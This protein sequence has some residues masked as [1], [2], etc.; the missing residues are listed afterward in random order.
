MLIAALAILAGSDDESRTRAL[1]TGSDDHSGTSHTSR[2]STI[3]ALAI[4]VGSSHD[5]SG[6]S[7]TSSW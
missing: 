2:Q 7:V 6:T 5:D 1:L 3:M 4:L